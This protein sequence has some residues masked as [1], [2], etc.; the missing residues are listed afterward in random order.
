ME[1]LIYGSRPWLYSIGE[2][3]GIAISLFRLKVTGSY[4]TTDSVQ[5]KRVRFKDMS[6]RYYCGFYGSNSKMSKYRPLYRGL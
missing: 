3:L 4:S 2:A 6:D 5:E 1:V